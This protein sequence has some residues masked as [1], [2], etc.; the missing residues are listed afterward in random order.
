MT[1]LP[2]F[3]AALIGVNYYPPFSADYRQL[4]E[5]GY[6]HKAVMRDDVAHFRRLG[7]GYVRLHVFDREVSHP[8]GSLDDNRHLELL[9]YLIDICA[10]N[11]LKT[12]LTPIAW[13]GNSKVWGTDG[14]SDHLDIRQLTGDRSTWPVQARY[15]GELL[16]HVNRYRGVSY[17]KDPAILAFEAINEPL[18]PAG[19]SQADI[20]EYVDMYVSAF[21][22]AGT[23]KPIYYNSWYDCNAALNASKADGA[24]GCYYPTGLVAGH[25]LEAPQLFRVEKSTL[26][27]AVSL[28]AGKKRMIYEFEAAD[29]PG[30]YMYPAMA[31]LF[32]SEGVDLAAV[33]QYDPMAIADRNETWNTHYLNLIYTPAKALSLAIAAEVFRRM[34]TGGV[35]SP[36]NDELR[37]PPFALSATK[38]VS[39]MVTET[40]YLYTNAPLDP[41]P[42]PAALRRVWGHGSSAV[43]SSDG[44]GAYFLDRASDGVW[45]LQLYPNI[46]SCEDPYINDAA[47]VKTVVVEGAVHMAVRLPD[48]GGLFRV[49]ATDGTQL[50][51]ASDGQVVLDPGD[52]VLWRNGVSEQKAVRAAKSLLLPR[53]VAP[54]AVASTPQVRTWKLPA[55]WSAHVGLE[56]KIDSIFADTLGLRFISV[57]DSDVTRTVDLQKG[58]NTLPAGVPG[59]GEWRVFTTAKGPKGDF[60]SETGRIWFRDS[61]G[62]WNLFDVQLPL[63]RGVVD[64]RLA[65]RFRS[66]DDRGLPAWNLH[67]L[68]LVENAGAVI[69]VPCDGPLAARLFP[70]AGPGT[71]LVVHARAAL[72]C[73]T[74]FELVL[75]Q[76]D[77]RPWSVKVPVMETWRDI[78]IPLSSMRYLANWDGAPAYEAGRL[79]DRRLVQNV[80][81]MLA[82]EYV[83]ESAW[84]EMHAIEVSSVT[85]E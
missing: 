53:Y 17:A 30:S 44:S 3:A 84:P 63:A 67:A 7:V 12:V 48:L 55:Q 22:K 13:F 11:G 6:D 40:D 82:R 68:N 16:A 78:R 27:Q 56:A 43:V 18:Y 9:D 24:T 23:S 59:T 49:R 80:R 76:N 65:W 34:P 31:K 32:R 69:N 70:D 58:E 47:P 26:S 19:M 21:R 29:T 61:F 4:S 10:S 14:F 45:R 38:D 50:A 74:G 28:A 71:T 5:H 60:S 52:Y 72:A 81:I 15:V 42:K 73:T 79:P 64:T 20:A 85:I 66:T 39:Q 46:F 83:P 51:T 1:G 75:W 54:R 2:L 62:E 33:F 37:F 25:A 36:S 77:R 41:P 8:D 35:Y 57:R